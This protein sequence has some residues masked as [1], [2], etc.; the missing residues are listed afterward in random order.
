MTADRDEPAR[1][2][3][4]IDVVREVTVDARQPVCIETHLFRLSFDLESFHDDLR[5]FPPG[6]V[7]RP[8]R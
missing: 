4:V 2:S 3:P 6:P 8:V 7:A 1:Q 5:S